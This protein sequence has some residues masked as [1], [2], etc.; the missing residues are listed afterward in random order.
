MVWRGKAAARFVLVTI[1]IVGLTSL[2]ID[3]SDM[4]GGSQSALGL[5]A[6]RATSQGCPEGMGEVDAASGRFCVDRYESSVGEGCPNPAPRS[7]QESAVNV[8][9]LKCA[10]RSVEGSVPWTNVAL[11]QA[12]ALCAKA[13]KRLP[14]AQEWYLASLGTSDGAHCNISS[15]RKAAAGA[16][17]QC[18]SGAGVYDLIGNVWELVDGEV[19]EGVYAGD[20]LP[21]EGYVALVGEDGLATQTTS[22]PQ[23]T[24]NDDYF[25]SRADGGTYVLM[26]GG[27][28]GSERDAGVY[29]AHAA[30][31]PDF[32]SDAIGFRCV[33]TL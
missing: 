32:S 8:N 3:A 27:F 30:I 22:T 28:Y 7:S 10:P 9:A 15:N 29:A 14:S 2:G 31:R 12:R 20:A 5:L 23:A 26:R 24:Y 17:A 21:E 13:G 11:H 6:D 25:W 1:G 16:H 19:K 18:T 4:L 33:T